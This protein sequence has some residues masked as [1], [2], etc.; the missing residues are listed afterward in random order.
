MRSWSS[1]LSTSW[2]NWH[3]AGFGCNNTLLESKPSTYKDKWIPASML[4]TE[5]WNLN[6]LGGI[7]DRG[8]NV[9]LQKATT[10][11]Q[12]MVAIMCLW[13][14]RVDWWPD[15]CLKHLPKQWLLLLYSLEEHLLASLTG[16]KG[17][18]RTSLGSPRAN[19]FR[20][21]GHC[22]IQLYTGMKQKGVSKLNH[23]IS[24]ASTQ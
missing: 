15:Q 7:S 6:V 2:L 10:N 22:I 8:K 23:I 14:S 5:E 9:L 12:V 24:I 4:H 18:G 3:N 13:E 19:R 16:R 11:Q 20:S 17:C 1:W 21:D